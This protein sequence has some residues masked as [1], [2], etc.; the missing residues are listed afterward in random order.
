MSYS[1]QTYLK[2]AQTLEKRRKKAERIQLARKLEI[3]EKIPDISKYEAQLSATGL[4]VVKAIGMGENAE[5]YIN[6]LSQINLSIQENIKNLLV[7]NGY[8]EDY[9]EIPY[10]CKKCGDTGFS[11]GYVCECRKDTL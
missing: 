2:A 9:L 10:T 1:N 7:K 6:Q 11:G 8:P 5:E 3:S 4:A